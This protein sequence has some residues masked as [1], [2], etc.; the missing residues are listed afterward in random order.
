MRA[1]TSLWP[2]QR[3]FSLSSPFRTLNKI[4]HLL[5]NKTRTSGIKQ[6][7]KTLAIYFIFERQKEGVHLKNCPQPL[8]SPLRV[9]STGHWKKRAQ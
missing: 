4:R 2:F 8:Y 3:R 7:K 1:A 6:N 9:R 5:G